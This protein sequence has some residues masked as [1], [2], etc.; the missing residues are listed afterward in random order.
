[1]PV[2]APASALPAL[3]AGAASSGGDPAT[4]LLCREE[5]IDDNNRLCG[6]RFALSA[7]AA[8]RPG[9]ESALIEALL[10]A[11]IPEFAQRRL[12]LIPL[13]LDAVLF[14]RHLALLAPNT[15]FVIAR[16][17]TAAVP[18]GGRLNALREGA[19]KVALAGLAD[20]TDALSDVDACDIVI[21]NLNAFGL[22]QFQ[23]LVR[24]LRAHAPALAICVEGVASWDEQRMCLALGCRYFLGEFVT[25]PD[26][27]DPDGKL[28][29]SRLAAIALLN[30][31]R[32]EA[33]LAEL[34]DAAKRDP[35]ITFQLLKWANSPAIGHAGTITSLGQAIV[36]LGRG[37][38]YRWLT[39]SMFRLGGGG[40]RDE[41][42]LEV[43]LTRAR[44]L[45][46][47]S[48]PVLAPAQR[49]ELFLVGMLSVFDVLLGMP[50]ANVLATMHLS[51]PV[52]EVLL[53]SGGPYG[54]F[55]MLALLLERG[56]S[57]RAAVLAVSLGIDAHS[58]APASSAAFGWAQ[59]SLDQ[60]LAG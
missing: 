47:V 33:A 14:Q 35:G 18:L 10:A 59:Q 36:V 27:P 53:R 17:Q 24:Q 28:D 39:V 1:M 6:Y 22:E 49:D 54:P 51:A 3:P 31:L 56:M 9:A 38:L 4:A 26:R 52:G 16:P 30:L 12:A 43:A 13:T 50:M 60:T 34:A 37:H 29:Q 8:C 44:L 2:P 15:V 20:A 7:S 19:C 11:R 55:L 42:L 48:A 46:L 45:E 32:G 58:L 41:A 40:G 5:I 57:E 23:A 25:Q 21:L